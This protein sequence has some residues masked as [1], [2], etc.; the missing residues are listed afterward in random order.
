MGRFGVEEADRDSG[1]K[2]G[3]A[4]QGR[5]DRMPDTVGQRVAI[6]LPEEL[7]APALQ[8]VCERGLGERRTDPLDRVHE[9]GKVGA[10]IDEGAEPFVDEAGYGVVPPQATIGPAHPL[11]GKQ[12][13][14]KG[15]QIRASLDRF[16][17]PGHQARAAQRHVEPLHGGATHFRP[18]CRR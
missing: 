5:H 7:W 9:I 10:V 4:V 2:G 13:I 15:H 18:L 12:M 6:E 14:V 3:H 11:G 16:Q 8:Q 1:D 17:E